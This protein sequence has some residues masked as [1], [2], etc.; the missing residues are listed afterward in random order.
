[1]S[2]LS[3]LKATWD[4]RNPVDELTFNF[5]EAKDMVFGHGLDVLVFVKGQMVNSYKDPSR[6]VAQNP[7]QHKESLHVVWVSVEAD[8]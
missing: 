1:M 7:F 5:E 3:K 6:L 8:G 4:S 2:E